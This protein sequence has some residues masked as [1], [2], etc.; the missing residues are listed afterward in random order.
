M[1]T[2][3]SRERVLDEEVRID[4]AVVP[5]A[6]RR[7]LSREWLVRRLREN[8]AELARDLEGHPDAGD[9]GS[10]NGG[11]RFAHGTVGIILECRHIRSREDTRSGEHGVER[12]AIELR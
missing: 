9:P 7:A 1:R 3:V 11:D 8:L 6:A 12:R 2:L 4:V 5:R 10:G